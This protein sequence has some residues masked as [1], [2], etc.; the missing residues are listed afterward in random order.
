MSHSATSVSAQDDRVWAVSSWYGWQNGEGCGT[1]SVPSQAWRVHRG[2]RCFFPAWLLRFQRE[3][4]CCR[5]PRQILHLSLPFGNSR[6]GA[7][8][9][10]WVSKNI[11]TEETHSV[12]HKGRENYGVAYMGTAAL[13]WQVWKAWSFLP[14]CFP[15]FYFVCFLL[16]VLIPCKQNAPQKL[17]KG[18]RRQFDTNSI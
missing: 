10:I 5:E 14:R 9:G 8:C 4:M 3:Y 6:P 1:P 18:R 17:W 11:I 7:C 16:M 2:T 12:E 15:L 13:Q